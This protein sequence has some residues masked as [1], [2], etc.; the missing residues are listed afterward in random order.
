MAGYQWT[1]ASQCNCQKV[2]LPFG[3]RLLYPAF[4]RIAFGRLR[5]HRGWA[6]LRCYICS[7][8]AVC[9]NYVDWQG[10]QFKI[11]T[12]FQLICSQ[13]VQN[14][15]FLLCGVLCSQQGCSRLGSWKISYQRTVPVLRNNELFLSPPTLNTNDSPFRVVGCWSSTYQRRHL[16][17]ISHGTNADIVWCAEADLGGLPG[18]EVLDATDVMLIGA[19]SSK[20]IRMLHLGASKQE[21]SCIQSV[22]ANLMKG[23]AQLE[24]LDLLVPLHSREVSSLLNFCV[25]P[26]QAHQAEKRIDTHKHNIVRMRLSPAVWHV[27][28]NHSTDYQISVLMTKVLGASDHLTLQ[29]SRMH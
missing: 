23:A 4:T 22:F 6:L 24:Q 5:V 7:I 25:K 16:K 15:C 28:P 21:Y 20:A 18:L 12:G 27:Q 2:L 13:C 14:W 11:G 3:S 10:Q 8:F 26:W 17:D 1:N 19:L 29:P 9:T